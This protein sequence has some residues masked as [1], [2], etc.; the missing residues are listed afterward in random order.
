MKTKILAH[1]G[2]S[3]YAPENTME[4]FRLGI[5]LGA[6]GIELD[7]HLTKDGEVAVFH[8]FTLA[9]MTGKPG[10][11]CDFTM[12]ELKRLDFPIPTLGEVYE[13]IEGFSK[14]QNRPLT[15]NVELKTTE[16]T[17]P[18]LPA[19]LL[20]LQGKIALSQIIYSSFNHYSLQTIRRLNPHVYIGLL[21]NLPLVDPQIYARHLH[22]NAIHP[23]WHIIAALPDIVADCHA[24]G[25]A[26]NTWT[27]NDPAMI[28]L[29]LSAGVDVIITDKPDVAI[30][31]MN[32]CECA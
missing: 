1:R 15:I 13:L 17:Y 27:V 30:A 32:P 6:D 20:D 28:R 16:E 23:P 19:K 22:A 26:V 25:I 12:A 3:A 29:M 2:A 31:Q 18:S 8:D 9:R 14:A 24:L 7:V 10:R 4:A 21:Y 5:E 11:V